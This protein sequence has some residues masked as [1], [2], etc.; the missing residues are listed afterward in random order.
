MSSGMVYLYVHFEKPWFLSDLL[1]VFVMGSLIKLFKFSSFKDSLYFLVPNM[2][3]N[4]VATIYVAYYVNVVSILLFNL[5]GWD[6]AALKSFNTPF[7]F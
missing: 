6:T 4:V 2:L 5:Q 1:S 3:M 7:S